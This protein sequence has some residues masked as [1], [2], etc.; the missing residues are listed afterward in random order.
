[1]KVNFFIVLY[2]WMK[3]LANGKFNNFSYGSKV[4]HVGAELLN[5]IA[6]LWITESNFY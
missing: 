1:M 4:Q 3:G 2:I 5:M 6:K